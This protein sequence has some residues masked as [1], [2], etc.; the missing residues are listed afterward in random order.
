MDKEAYIYTKFKSKLNGDDCAIVGDL[1]YCK[2]LFVEGVHFRR[3]WL[4]MHEI[5]AKAMLVN[6]SDMIAKNAKPKYALI[7]LSLPRDITT[8]QI[9]ELCAGLNKTAQK[10]GIEIIGGDTI[11]DDKIYISVTMIGK[12][13]KPIFRNGAKCGHLIAHTGKLGY[14][15]IDLQILLG[16]GKRSEISPHSRMLR[17][18]L[19]AKFFYKAAK[20]ISASMDISDG[21]GQDLERLLRASGVGMSWLVSPKEYVLNSGEEY[22]ILFAFEPKFL[23]KIYE[24]ASKTKTPISVIGRAEERNLDNTCE[25]KGERHHFSE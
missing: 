16:G 5:G 12:C 17:P 21:L 1:A 19:R 3:E 18:E 24:I 22:E 11:S 9:D 8:A 6:I 7:G 14:V 23:S 2:D 20:Y 13:K 15:G 25:F 10:W 4:S